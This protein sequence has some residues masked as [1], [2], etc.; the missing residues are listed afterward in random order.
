MFVYFSG[1]P[2][3]WVRFATRVPTRYWEGTPDFTNKLPK[4][5]ITLHKVCAPK[6]QLAQVLLN[7]FP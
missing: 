5:F 4:Y 3:R 6:E 7:L 2:Y 1:L